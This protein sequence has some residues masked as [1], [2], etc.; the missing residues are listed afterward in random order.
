MRLFLVMILLVASVVGLH[1]S[2]VDLIN[3]IQK[4]KVALKKISAVKPKF[5][6]EKTKDVTQEYTFFEVLDDPTMTRYVGLDGK[7]SQALQFPIKVSIAAANNELAPSP[8]ENIVKP[9]SLTIPAT[10]HNNLNSTI[11]GILR[12]P[13]YAVWVGSFRDEGQAGALKMYLQKKGFDAFLVETKIAGDIWYRVFMDRYANEQKAQN[14]AR[15]ARTDFK[16]NA[17]VVSK[18]N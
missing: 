15:L 8:V 1:F 16:L 14:A 5:L 11:S 17:V 4:K 6:R 13:R 2:D 12:L 9:E 18:T 7:T 10:K 3:G